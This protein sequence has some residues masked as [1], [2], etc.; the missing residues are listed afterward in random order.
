MKKLIKA[1]I[2]VLLA[3]AI[4]VTILWVVVIFL[5]PDIGAT[6]ATPIDGD[7]IPQYLA[8]KVT[9]IEEHTQFNFNYDGWSLYGIITIIAAIVGVIIA[10]VTYSAQESVEKH[11]KNV[12]VSA[13]LGSLTDLL[14]H[15]YRNAVCTGSILLKYRHDESIHQKAATSYPSEAN[16]LKLQTQPEIYILPIDIIN[17]DIFQSMTEMRKLMHNYNC[18]IDVATKHFS[19]KGMP[20][21]SLRYDHDSLL[22]KP[23]LLCKQSLALRIMLM[24]A[25]RN[26]DNNLRIIHRRK[27]THHDALLEFFY[28]MIK[29]HIRKL[30]DE[31]PQNINEIRQ[32][33]ATP[34]NE[35]FSIICGMKAQES[36]LYRGFKEMCKMIPNPE[37]GKNYT[38]PDGIFVRNEKN[39]PL[40]INRVELLKYYITTMGSGKAKTKD[41][42]HKAWDA[43]IHNFKTFIGED[44]NS[45]EYFKLWNLEHKELET[46]DLFEFFITILKVDIALEYNRIG[47]IKFSSE[48]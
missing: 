42:D 25:E 23:F 13:Q 20:Y 35:V 17:D 3:I 12:S 36:G 46:E 11:T 39:G 27:S 6:A 24:D 1:S 34:T 21:E 47:M 14:R 7:N 44:A 41:T 43:K 33:M 4:L 18:E 9:A 38:S 28:E 19:T 31:M 32:W 5:R 48:Q 2:I 37:A 45:N 26:N 15:I 30:P 8:D 29:E 22:F 40:Q 16:M 10:Y